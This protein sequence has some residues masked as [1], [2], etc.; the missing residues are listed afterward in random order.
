VIPLSTVGTLGT[1]SCAICHPDTLTLEERDA[2]VKAHNRMKAFHRMMDKRVQARLHVL[3]DPEWALTATGPLLV[4][5]TL[6][7]HLQETFYGS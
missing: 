6:C 5:G 7:S 2:A 4:E 3:T 1:L